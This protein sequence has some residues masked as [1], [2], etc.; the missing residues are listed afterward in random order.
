MA[1]CFFVT[2]LHGSRR[3]YQTLF[4]TV[5][6]ER[7]EA[8][9]VG[10]DLLPHPATV[11]HSIAPAVRDFHLPDLL[12]GFRQ[13]RA[14][15][16]DHYPSVFLIMGN[17]DPKSIEPAFLEADQEG[18][19]HYAHARKL[20]LDHHPVYGYACIP[21]SPFQLKDWELYDVS[22][23]VDPGCVSP[24]EGFRTVE[25]ESRSIRFTTIQQQLEDLR[26]SDNLATAIMLFHTP[27]HQTALD[28]A[29]LDGKM[30]DHAPVDVHIG[31][32]AVRRFIEKHQPLICLHGHVHESARLTGRWS[33]QIGRTFLYSAAHDGEE[34]ALVRFD[35]ES[36][37][38]AT[39]ELL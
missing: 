20:T 12:E 2:D 10:G 34:L 22:R 16:D 37:E 23:F 35:T 32:I 36:P 17:D 31:S 18:L 5:A 29:A 39:R 27:P 4:T 28:R 7:P 30:V 25:V 38:T 1:T 24:E 13:L 26:G 33:D 11:K 19:W 6:T 21:P 3:R 15:L 9:F 14:A 8:V